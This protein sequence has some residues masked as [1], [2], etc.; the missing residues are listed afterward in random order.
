VRLAAIFIISVWL[1]F[2]S[3]GCFSDAEARWGQGG[4]GGSQIGYLKWN[5]YRYDASY[6][7]TGNSLKWEIFAD[8]R[9][10]ANAIYKH[11]N[12]MESVLKNGGVPRAWDKFFV[13]D[14]AMSP[15][16]STATMIMDKRVYV[17]KEA[18]NDC[19]MTIIKTHA[20]VLEDEFFQGNTR[21]DHSDI[22]DDIIA[23][24][25]CSPY[26]TYLEDF[27]EAHGK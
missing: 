19:A 18:Q 10:S 3:I 24:E 26:R 27:V 9:Y 11:V 12:W 22:A 5:S 2:C 20:K 16:Y 25:E 23:S 13:I 1:F 8:S 15:Y 21:V 7:I 6:E 14:A 4:Q 17:L